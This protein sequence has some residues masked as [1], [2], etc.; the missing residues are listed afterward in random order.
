MVN[1]SFQSVAMATPM[2]SH[3]C[4]EDLVLHDIEVH[5]EEA[6][7]QSGAEGISLHQADL[8]V[9]WLVAQQVFL[10]GDHVL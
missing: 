1:Y 10:R 2:T 6:W 5:G 8:G 9:G 3:L 4:V 7:L